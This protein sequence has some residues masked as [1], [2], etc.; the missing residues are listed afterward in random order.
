V[1][2]GALNRADLPG[3]AFECG[4]EEGGGR[5]RQRQGRKAEQRIGVSNNCSC[6]PFQ[7]AA[8]SRSV[9]A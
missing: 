7:S 5:Q 2:A 8:A 9:L 3:T 4:A 6:L 1:P